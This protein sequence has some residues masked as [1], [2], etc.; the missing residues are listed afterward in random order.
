MKLKIEGRLY[1][2]RVGYINLD[3][4]TVEL[5]VEPTAWNPAALPPRLTLGE[6]M[7]DARHELGG[8]EACGVLGCSVCREGL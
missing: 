7:D 6:A 3:D 4:V 8:P 1:N 5:V 2:H